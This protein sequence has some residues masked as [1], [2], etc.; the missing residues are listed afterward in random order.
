MSLDVKVFEDFRDKLQK[1]DKAS[2]EIIKQAIIEIANRALRLIKNATPV[3]TG[4]LKGD[5]FI[6]NMKKS[7]N[8]WRIDISNLVEYA[9]Y[10]EYGH[11]IVSR[12]GA[13][14]GW[15]EGV[16]MMTISL[17]AVEKRVD[18]IVQRNLREYFAEALK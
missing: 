3:D 17:K 8:V 18:Q 6:S 16:F 1:V 10:V 5:W 14:I 11:R 12:D 9:P 4:F 7:G 13:T 2:D 15:H